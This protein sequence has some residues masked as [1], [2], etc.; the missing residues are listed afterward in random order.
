MSIS[1]VYPLSLEE[2][3]KGISTLNNKAVDRDDM[4]VERSGQVVFT[5]P[6]HLFNILTN[7]PPIQYGTRSFIYADDVCITVQALIDLPRTL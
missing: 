6:Q 1:M 2:Y 5:H 3:R 7:D 4:L